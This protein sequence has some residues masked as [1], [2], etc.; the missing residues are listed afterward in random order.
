MLMS[1]MKHT[2]S[3]LA[4]LTSRRGIRILEEHARLESALALARTTMDTMQ[5]IRELSE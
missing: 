4:L 2:L 3:P 5:H 1:V